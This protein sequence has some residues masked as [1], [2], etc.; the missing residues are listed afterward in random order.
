[1]LSLALKGSRHLYSQWQLVLLGRKKMQTL[2]RR[3]EDDDSVSESH[4]QMSEENGPTYLPAQVGHM[5]PDGDVP[6][7]TSRR[8]ANC[9]AVRP[10]CKTVVGSSTQ[11]KD[12]TFLTSR[13][14]MI[15]VSPMTGV[16]AEPAKPQ[17]MYPRIQC[18]NR[19][20]SWT[21]GYFN[22]SHCLPNIFRIVPPA[23]GSWT[24]A[25]RERSRSQTS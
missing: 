1:M 12:T 19:R 8:S 21:S 22:S 13:K 17:K 5:T 10:Q 16:R 15:S 2:N 9:I 14:L 4:T 24:R 7:S 25:I 18:R 23:D 20:S 3:V 11:S 6:K